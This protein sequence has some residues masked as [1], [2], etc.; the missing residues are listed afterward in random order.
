MQ[1]QK[2]TRF[3][4]WSVARGPGFGPPKVQKEASAFTAP[5]PVDVD[6][7]GDNVQAKAFTSK[8]HEVPGHA[9]ATIPGSRVANLSAEAHKEARGA[10]LLLGKVLTVLG[11]L[12]FLWWTLG[13]WH[14]HQHDAAEV[15]SLEA[16]LQ[17]IH[18]KNAELKDQRDHLQSSTVALQNEKAEA[19]AHV[20]DQSS[21]LEDR[22]GLIQQLQDDLQAVSGA[23][24]DLSTEMA[25]GAA[26]SRR[27][28]EASQQTL[29]SV[30]QV[31]HGNQVRL[32]TQKGEIQ[33]LE[34]RSSLLQNQ[35]QVAQKEAS[36]FSS[37]LQEAKTQQKFLQ[38]QLKVAQGTSDALRKQLSEAKRED[39]KRLHEATEH[40]AQAV[41]KVQEQVK[42]SDQFIQKLLHRLAIATQ[43]REA[44][45]V[46]VAKLENQ[47][48]TKDSFA[49][50]VAKRLQLLSE[51]TGRRLK[52]K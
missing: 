46:R 20:F 7:N 11:S 19:E 18:T 28:A 31:M 43:Q 1:V 12:L 6:V 34:N 8:Y 45:E 40:E 26:A 49:K 42:S 22:N 3:G 47:L 35:I 51:D 44:G 52:I 10:A 41:S 16:E 17:V 29:A 38:K 4:R 25:Q 9:E 48:K 14:L 37:S 2:K 23:A 32:A 30:R 24:S 13:L 15:K 27:A 50:D 5:L 33:M 21:E 39:G 36:H